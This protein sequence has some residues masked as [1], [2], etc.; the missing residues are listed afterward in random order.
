MISF[1]SRCVYPIT[2]VN[3]DIDDEGI[4]SACRTFEEILKITDQQ[5]KLRK[6]KF[7]EIIEKH[8]KFT[9]GDYD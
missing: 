6:D 7:V 9:K 1:C 8:K 3:L 5:W 4:C 2:A